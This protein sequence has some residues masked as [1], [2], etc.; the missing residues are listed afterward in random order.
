M[1]LQSHDVAKQCG[2]SNHWLV[3]CC[4]NKTCLDSEKRFVYK[5]AP[6]RLTRNHVGQQLSQG[7]L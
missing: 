6:M 5:G 1:S 3:S 7:Q 4:L 2:F